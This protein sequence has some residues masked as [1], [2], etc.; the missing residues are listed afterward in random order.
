MDNESRTIQPKN[1]ANV[2]TESRKT[3]LIYVLKA[4]GKINGIKIERRDKTLLVK[5]G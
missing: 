1:K 3:I 4:H 2:A 5:E